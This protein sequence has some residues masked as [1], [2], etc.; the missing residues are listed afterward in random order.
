M[1]RLLLAG[2]VHANSQHMQAVMGHACRVDADA[3]VQLGDWGYGFGLSQRKITS[4]KYCTFTDHVSKF[5]QRTENVA[6][7]R[8]K[9]P[10]FWIDGNHSNFD[11]LE[12]VC[13]KVGLNDGDTYEVAP[14]VFYV[15][16][17]T[18]LMFGA[19]RFLCCGGGTSIDKKQR[20]PF[21]S[22]WPQEA[23]TDADVE[24]CAEAG[25][26]DVMLTHDFPW[27]VNVVDRHLDPYWGVEAQEQV[28]HSRNQI[29]KIAGRAKPKHLI[30]GHLHHAYQEDILVED[31]LIHVRG[32]TCDN[33][34][35]ATSTFLLDTEDL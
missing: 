2:D 12:E 18:L 19:K 10:V 4:E 22:W 8:R 6:T 23:I 27:E 9:I 21:V 14:D 11:H 29:S 24:K 26:V 13:E 34:S 28:I 7:G 1:T 16:R 25:Q 17:G 20:T 5:V 31:W 30:H 3:V 33:H 35:M 15:P 32:L